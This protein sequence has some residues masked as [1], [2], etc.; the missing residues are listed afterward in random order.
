MKSGSEGRVR[1]LFSQSISV[2]RAEMLWSNYGRGYFDCSRR[3]VCDVFGFCRFLTGPPSTWQETG[4]ITQ[5]RFCIYLLYILLPVSDLLFPS[6]PSDMIYEDP[7]HPGLYLLYSIFTSSF[8]HVK[9]L[10]M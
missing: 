1:S 8:V 3:S 2:F 9:Y 5:V 7:D 6:Q 10:E 4:H